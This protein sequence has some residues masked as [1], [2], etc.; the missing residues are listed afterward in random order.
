MSNKIQTPVIFIVGPTCIG[1]SEFA[2]NLAKKINGEIIN[3]DSMQVYSN[4]S[5]LTARPKLKEQ[6]KIPHHLYGYVDGTIRYNVATWC[7]DV[8]NILEKNFNK[9]KHSIVVGGTGM[10]IEK[11][12]NGLV[13]MPTIPEKIKNESENF[14]TNY[15][16]DKLRE[17]VIK[18]DNVASK[19]ISLND[20]NRLRRIWEVYKYTKKNLTF[21]KKNKNK[22]FLS[23][24]SYVIYLFIPNRAQI[25][26]RVNERFIHMINSGAVEEVKKLLELDLPNSFP[27]MR[28]NGVPEITS[29]LSG[30][31]PIE[32]CIA[33]GQLV[34]RHYVKRQ[35]SWW[36]TANL[37]ITKQFDKFPSEID[38]NSIKIN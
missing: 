22:N 37:K 23:N 21:W 14:L 13:Q 34:T 30:L 19:K 31:F 6:K 32:E 4:L 2:I 16:I 17:E 5:I 29:F 8:S 18:I 15:G 36:L 26:N 33:K 20:I 1:K 9:K 38:I 28:A 24:R 10:Y 11:F 12:I 25:Y 7:N 3:A 27:I 35:L